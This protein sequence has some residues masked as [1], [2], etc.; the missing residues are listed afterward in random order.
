[1]TDTQTPA[2]T[3]SA[4]EALAYSAIRHPKCGQ[5]WTG[6]GRAHCA[7]CCRTFSCDSAAGQH[8]KGS[9]GGGRHCVDPATV[10]LV[11]V[12]KP[13][14]VMWQNPGPDPAATRIP[15]QWSR[16]QEAADQP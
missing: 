3:Q 16:D 6:T 1:M 8:R 14:G 2:D 7:A 4:P 13:W 15:A 9:Y 10:G 5:H 12:D 11:A